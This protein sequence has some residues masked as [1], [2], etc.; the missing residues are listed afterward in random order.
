MP[1]WAQHIVWLLQQPDVWSLVAMHTG[2][3]VFGYWS[4]VRAWGA[5]RRIACALLMGTIGL[6]IATYALIV[7]LLYQSF[8]RGEIPA[9]SL[10]FAM[11]IAGVMSLAEIV[12]AMGALVVAAQ[13][14][15]RRSHG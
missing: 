2:A 5:G 14:L 6:I 8:V 4:F 3:A 11:Q 15:R 7:P 13:W 10:Q 1:V 12:A 9:A